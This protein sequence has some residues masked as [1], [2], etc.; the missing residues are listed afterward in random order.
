MCEGI[1]AHGE[2]VELWWKPH[3]QRA[4]ADAKRV[5]IKDVLL[6]S[7]N[8]ACALDITDFG[9]GEGGTWGF[10][11]PGAGEAAVNSWTPDMDASDMSSREEV[12]DRDDGLVTN[13]M[14]MIEPVQLFY[15]VPGDPNAD[16]LR[17]SRGAWHSRTCARR[18][19][20]RQTS[21]TSRAVERCARCSAAFV[22]LNEAVSLSH[23]CAHCHGSSSQ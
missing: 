21:S 22:I 19:A 12:R 14:P 2:T 7:F 4:R 11:P 17:P 5:R 9:D 23:V 10:Q 18:G 3:R 20:H 13:R 1:S 15:G 16:T 8:F 6:V